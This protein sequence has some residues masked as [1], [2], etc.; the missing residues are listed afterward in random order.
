MK[1]SAKLY[2]KGIVSLQEAATSAEVSLYRMMEYIQR[3][4]IRPPTQTREDFQK[5]ISRSLK[6]LSN[7][8]DR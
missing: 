5:E 1:E 2:Q 8:E 7:Q 3:E 4:Q 6:W